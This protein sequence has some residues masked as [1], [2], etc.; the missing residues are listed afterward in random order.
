MDALDLVP[1]PS[2]FIGGEWVSPGSDRLRTHTDPSTGQSTRSFAEADGK[3]VD[4]AVASAR[5]ALAGWT[6]LAP[7]RRQALLVAVADLIEAEAPNLGALAALEM[8]QPVRSATA[9]AVHAA[10]W[11]RYFAGWAD[12]LEGATVPVAPGEVLDYVLPEPFGV[13]AAI[14]PWNGPVMSLAVKLAPAL[15][16]GNTV[17]AKPPL[18]APFSSLYLAGLFVRAGFPPGVVNVVVGGSVAGE[19]L[20][21]HP[22]IDKISFTGGEVAARAVAKAAAQYHTPVVMELGGKSASLIFEDADPVLVGTLAARFGLQQNSGQGCFLPTRVFVH[23]SLY[24]EVVDQVVAS[25]RDLTVGDPF[26]PATRMGPVAGAVTRDRILNVIDAARLRGDGELLVGGGV[27][28]GLNEAGSFVAPTVFGA[29]DPA[30]PLAQEEIF[31]PVLAMSSFETEQEAVALANGTRYGLAGYVWTNHLGRAH[32]LASALR[33]GSVSINSM[34]TL[35]PG[36]PFGGVGASGHGLEGG[37]WGLS[38]FLRP[39]NV[40]VS[41][42]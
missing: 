1:P 14:I 39:K 33:A 38:E 23:H 37:R 13:V 32:R 10:S 28:E 5:A 8:G 41:L 42:R 6:A 20:C 19:A 2:L 34:A 18:E 35:P 11:F 27:V 31:G 30:S 16:A 12:K 21:G 36:A 7:V 9:A 4:D 24:E 40:H 3:D 22:G 25:V 29:V 17:V 26:E 15:T